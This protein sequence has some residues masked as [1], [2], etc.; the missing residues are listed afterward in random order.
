MLG[1]TMVAN[2]FAVGGASIAG[3]CPTV[4]HEIN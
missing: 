1:N 4:S 2:R 3:G